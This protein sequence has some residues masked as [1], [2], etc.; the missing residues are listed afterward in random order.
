VPSRKR[1]ELSLAKTRS[2]IT[3]GKHLLRAVDARSAYM[4]RLRDLVDA[5]TSDLGGADLVSESE[6]RLVRRAALLTIQCEMYDKKFALNDGEASPTDI[7]IYQRLTNTLRRTLESLGLSR[8]SR[9]VT[10]TLDEY[11]EAKARAGG[12]HDSPRP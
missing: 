8:R 11:L 1:S 9:D 6:Q 10:P 3:N 4:R 2:A 5:H 12:D 7:E